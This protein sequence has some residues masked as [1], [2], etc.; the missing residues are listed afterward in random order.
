MSV[1]YATLSLLKEQGGKALKGNAFNNK[2]GEGD[3]PLNSVDGY[4]ASTIYNREQGISVTSRITPI[5]NILIAA[6]VC[7]SKRDGYLYLA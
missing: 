6:G 2:L 7:E 5:S 1:F 4:V 3:L